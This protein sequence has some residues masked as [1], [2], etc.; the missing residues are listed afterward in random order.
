M[1][2]IRQLV[3]EEGGQGLTEYAFI[4]MLMAV[5]AIGALSTM[6]EKLVNLYN[7]AVAKFP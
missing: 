7:D 3:V 6:G 2:A 1:R 4:L 5:A